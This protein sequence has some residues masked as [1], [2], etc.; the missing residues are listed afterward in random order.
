MDAAGRGEDV[1]GGLAVRAGCAVGELVGVVAL[2]LSAGVFV[3]AFLDKVGG[4][5]GA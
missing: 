5:E 4:F 1:A 3:F 2:G